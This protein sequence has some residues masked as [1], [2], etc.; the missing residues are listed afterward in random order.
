ME[1]LLLMFVYRDSSIELHD[2]TLTDVIY[3]SYCAP[4]NDVL[5]SWKQDV[6]VGPELLCCY[7]LRPILEYQQAFIDFLNR[8]VA[9][10]K[11][12]ASTTSIAM[13]F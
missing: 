5:L 8:L 9:E 10:Q 3:N 7:L 11:V 1:L 2:C 4:W 12:G 13:Y 6:I